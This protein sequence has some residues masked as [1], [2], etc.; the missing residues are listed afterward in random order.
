ML[1]HCNHSKQ[2]SFHTYRSPSL[3]FRCNPG[4]IGNCRRDCRACR[5][6]CRR[7]V[8]GCKGRRRCRWSSHSTWSCDSLDLSCTLAPGC[9]R[10]LR[11]LHSIL[12]DRRTCRSCAQRRCRDSSRRRTCRGRRQ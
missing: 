11:G 1:N 8:R 6:H 10:P 7:M 4:C 12:A 2:A 9:R 3:D 5:R